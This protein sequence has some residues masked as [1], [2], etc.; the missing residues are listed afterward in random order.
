MLLDSGFYSENPDFTRNLLRILS[1][2]MTVK[3]PGCVLHFKREQVQGGR[4][5]FG[6]TG[7]LLHHLQLPLLGVGRW[8][9]GVGKIITPA[10]LSLLPRCTHFTNY[11]IH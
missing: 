3:A 5:H 1:K 7:E 4:R 10:L 6:E 8:G 2:K 11:L 9:G